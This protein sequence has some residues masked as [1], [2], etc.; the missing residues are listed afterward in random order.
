[1][2]GFSHN[3][4]PPPPASRCSWRRIRPWSSSGTGAT[5]PALPRGSGWRPPFPRETFRFLRWVTFGTRRSGPCCS[6]DIRTWPC[7]RSGMVSPGSGACPRRSA[8]PSRAGSSPVRSHYRGH[9]PSAPVD[10]G[11]RLDGGIR[12]RPGYGGG[13]AERMPSPHPGPTTAPGGHGGCPS[14][15]FLLW[16]ERRSHGDRGS[17][18][19]PARGPSLIVSWSPPPS[20]PTVSWIGPESGVTQPSS[21]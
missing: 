8:I 4:R 15:P 1:M 3:R 5:S 21:P 16:L 13:H 9:R 7:G 12:V 6:W 19:P 17:S 18:C 10:P 2:V 20:P 14:F 11:D